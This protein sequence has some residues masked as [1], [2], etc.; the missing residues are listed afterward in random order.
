MTCRYCKHSVIKRTDNG[1]VKMFC[2]GTGD[3]VNGFGRC[4][5]YTDRQ[6]SLCKHEKA[7]A[8]SDTCK[9]CADYPEKP[10]FER[11]LQHV[12]SARL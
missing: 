7:P 4:N 11:R 12:Y 2:K 3:G 1:M 6:C 8:D 9:Y 10:D 5:D